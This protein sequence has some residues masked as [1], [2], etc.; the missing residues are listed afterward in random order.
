[1]A[2]DQ[3]A[4]R[5]WVDQLKDVCASTLRSVVLLTAEDREVL[6]VRDGIGPDSTQMVDREFQTLM[7]DTVGKQGDEGTSDHGELLCVSRRFDDAIELY[8][9]VSATTGVGVA[10]DGTAFDQMDDPVAYL[11]SIIAGRE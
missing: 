6:Y 8:F 3:S 2:I 10:L 9:P 4:D 5:E 7:L 1:M 11:Q